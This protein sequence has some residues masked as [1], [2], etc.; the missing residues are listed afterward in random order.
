[1]GR[2]ARDPAT[3]RALA[4]EFE[5]ERDEADRCARDLRRQADDALRL[6]RP[7]QASELRRMASRDTALAHDRKAIAKRLRTR[8]TRSENEA[9]RGS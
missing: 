3:L 8:A 5:D 1:M 2:Y 6:G 7:S 9:R 4:N